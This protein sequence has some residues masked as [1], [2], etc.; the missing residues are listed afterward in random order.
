MFAMHWVRDIFKGPKRQNNLMIDITR[1]S[2]RY[3]NIF[4]QNVHMQS[5]IL[6]HNV[7]GYPVGWLS[8]SFRNCVANTG[9]NYFQYCKIALLL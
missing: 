7:S 5:T 3:V 8:T 4:V 6:S 1:T 2:F 9:Q